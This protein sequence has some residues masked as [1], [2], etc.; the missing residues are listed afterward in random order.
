VAEPAVPPKLKVGVLLAAA[1][2]DLGGWLADGS[3][4]EAAGADAL[5]LTVPGTDLDPLALAAALAT[6]TVRSLLVTALPAAGERSPD[7]A[8]TLAT[9][10]R[11]SRGRL[12]VLLDGPGERA[13]DPAAFRPAA[14]RPAAMDPAAFGPTAFRR[15]A[16]DPESFEHGTGADGPER[17]LSVPTPDGRAGW[18]ATLLD[19]AG[20]GYHGLVVPAGPRLLDILRNPDDPAARHDLQLA[21]G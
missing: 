18:R 19:A 13:A 6:L 11:L 10:D 12:R 5:W 17:W 14:F 4:F 8:R 9:V 7:L 16:A 1:P 3:S 21:Q 15:V 2:G 20:R